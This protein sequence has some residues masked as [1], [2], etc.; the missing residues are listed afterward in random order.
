MRIKRQESIAEVSGAVEIDMEALAA[1]E[2]GKERPNEEI[3]LLL[4]SHFD[5]KDDE[6]DSIWKLAGYELEPEPKQTVM[7]TPEDLRIVYTDMVHV[8][9]NNFGVVMNFMQN[10]GTNH[11]L[12]I[13]R[14]G[15]SREHAEKVL[16]VL[17]KTLQ[18]AR[19]K[20]LPAPEHR[21]DKIEPEA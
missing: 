18:A 1:I 2:Q 3:L 16:E 14:V 19:P 10:A 17:Q 9:V 15:M 20:Q 5:M 6:A 4:I 21:Q 7:M 12:A 13:S 11:P 8:S